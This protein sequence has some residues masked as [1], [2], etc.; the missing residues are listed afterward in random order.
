MRRVR[1]DERGLRHQPETVLSGTVL[2]LVCFGVVMVYSATSATALLDEGDPTGL[3][4]RQVVYA[5]LGLAAFLVAARARMGMLRRI[6]PLALAVSGVLLAVVLVPG[7]GTVVNGSRRWIDLG[8]AQLQPS[9]LAKLGLALWI[10]QAVHREPRRLTARGGL[11][12]Y[13]V[14]TGLFAVLVLVEPDLGTTTT[15]TVMAFAMLVVAG[16]RPARLAAIAGVGALLAALAIALEPYRRER[17]LI[18]LDPWSDPHGA[19]FQIVQAEI[20]LGSGGLGGVGIGDGLQKV[21][22]LPEAHTDMIVAT[23]G[24]ELG[25]LGVIGLLVAFG[26]IAICGFQIAL[27]AR[28]LHQQVLAAGITTLIVVQAAVNFGAVLGLLPVTGVPLPFVSFGG[29]SLVILLASAGI[30]VNIGRRCA[31]DPGAGGLRVVE[32]EG[33]DRHG[34]DGRARDAGA[35]ARRGAVGAGG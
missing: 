22:Y 9:E 33:G 16:A 7:I 32:G 18:F 15:L 27:R 19:G 28:D 30:L 26:V 29:S 2:L 13:V 8:M 17:L 12:P 21:F 35:R 3:V 6:G 5:V 20:A 14:V 4:K 31:P 23:V 1:P 11:I 34:R 25:L 24:E 10:A